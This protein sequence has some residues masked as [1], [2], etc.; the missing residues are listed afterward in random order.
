MVTTL[1]NNFACTG[2]AVSTGKVYKEPENGRTR[3]SMRGGSTMCR[4]YYVDEQMQ[5]CEVQGESRVSEKL[6][7]GLVCEVK[8]TKQNSFKGRH[9]RSFTLIELLVVIA[10]IA[11]LA[12]MLL[13]ALKTAREAANQVV[14][15]NNLKQ[16]GLAFIMYMNDH[17]DYLPPI[18]PGRYVNTRGWCDIIFPYHEGVDIYKCP[19][20][21]ETQYGKALKTVNTAY[22]FNSWNVYGSVS[23]GYNVRLHSNNT[24]GPP[25]KFSTIKDPVTCI[26]VLDSDYGSGSV[27]DGNNYYTVSTWSSAWSG[28]PAT[29]HSGGSNVLFAD[30]HVKW[31]QRDTLNDNYPAWWTDDGE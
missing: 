24:K 3:S 27:A 31:Y 2:D 9:L 30:G 23:Y 28:I 7:H 14:C 18:S 29:W 21:P 13:P 22:A 10:I 6:M 16:M 19:S 26:L 11:I 25:I 5:S 8:R 12:A 1:A 17:N 4:H 15:M 20:A